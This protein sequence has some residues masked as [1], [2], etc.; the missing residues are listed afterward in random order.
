MQSMQLNNIIT[1]DRHIVEMERRFPQATGDFS[2]LLYNIALAAKLITRDVRKAGLVDILGITGTSNSTGD[3]QKKLDVY[4]NDVMVNS[5]NHDGNV[6]VLGS[7]EVDEIIPMDESAKKGKYVVLFDPLDGS[8]NI[9]ANVSIGTIWSIF[10]RVTPTGTEGTLKDA[11]QP[12]YK[13]MASGY[14][15]YGSSTMFVYTTGYGVH[16]F[17]Y[18]PS[19]GE[20]ILSHPN[21]RTPRKGKIYSINEGNWHSFDE[22]TKR[23]C[24]YL[25]EEDPASGR[26]YTTRYIGS[27]V[28]DFHRNL[29]Y[30]GLYIYPGTK[31]APN[32]KLRLLYENN[33]LAFIVEQAG[34]KATDGKQRILDIVPTELHQR[35]PLFIG[36]PDDVDLAM[37]FIQQPETSE[38]TI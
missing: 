31:K 35:T 10:K 25:R 22:A 12:G 33:P 28:A 13:Q 2:K 5:L 8:S 37:K 11:L 3:V 14:I 26:P 34:G 6:C 4:S 36:S 1:I 17:T 23:L 18:D 9:D 32:G 27:L 38:V 24:T 15:L 21:I 20:F 7:E 19:I 30:G 29:L 16:G